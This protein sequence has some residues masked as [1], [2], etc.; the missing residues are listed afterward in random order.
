MK[1]TDKILKEIRL[2]YG[3][4]KLERNDFK[5]EP[6]LIFQDYPPKPY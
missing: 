6:I 1:I 3:N 2:E 5:K 4:K